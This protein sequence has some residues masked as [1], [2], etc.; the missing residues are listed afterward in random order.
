MCIV[1]KLLNTGYKYV[2]TSK[3]NQ[4]AIE[5]VFSVIRRHSNI[6]P[7]ALQFVRC[8]K[9][10]TVSQFIDSRKRKHMYEED[11]DKYY[12]DLFQPQKDTEQMSP[13][14]D[15][16]KCMSMFVTDELNV[17]LIG[18]VV[19][20][21]IINNLVGAA[22]AYVIKKKKI[23]ATCI[24]QFV[25]NADKYCTYTS[26]LSMKSLTNPSTLIRDYILCVEAHL[27]IHL[28]ECSSHSAF[29][30]HLMHVIKQYVPSPTNICKSCNA[31]HWILE[32]YVYIREII[33]INETKRKIW[34]TQTKSMASKSAYKQ[35]IV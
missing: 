21:N 26:A 19:E 4:D 17:T 30:A 10:L 27:Q 11:S 9:W 22:I 12:V 2:L 6:N 15:V 35:S 20:I 23:C 7:T 5:N 25:G 33:H 3:L 24:K 29:H 28:N 13:T 31:F 16:D 32:R 8:L 34:L 18:D 1:S 14:V